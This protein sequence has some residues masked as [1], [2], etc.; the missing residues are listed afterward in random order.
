MAVQNLFECTLRMMY[1]AIKVHGECVEMKE[2]DNITDAYK[3]FLPSLEDQKR[4][5]WHVKLLWSVIEE[6]KDVPNWPTQ[7]IAWNDVKNP[8]EEESYTLYIQKIDSDN[9]PIPNTE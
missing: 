4:Y 1:R 3:H 9:D 5:S 7:K 2:F 6:F 8:E